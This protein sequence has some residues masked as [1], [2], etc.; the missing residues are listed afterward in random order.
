MSEFRGEEDTMRKRE[1][2]LG[3][4]CNEL[5]KYILITSVWKAPT[6]S[7]GRGTELTLS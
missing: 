2:Y 1:G 7:W 4:V 3:T 5:A 6:Q